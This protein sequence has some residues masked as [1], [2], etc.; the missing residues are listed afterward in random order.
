MPSVPKPKRQRTKHFFKE[1]RLYRD[2]TQ[3]QALGRLGWSQSKI[4]RIEQGKTP[5]NEDDLAA[6]SVAYSCSVT[7]LIEV[8]PFKEGE[9]IDLVGLLRKAKPEQKKQAIAIL[10][11]LLAAS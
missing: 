8:D 1:W 9:V 7:D 3:E 11:T 2:L 5:Y 6:A 10:R 4:S